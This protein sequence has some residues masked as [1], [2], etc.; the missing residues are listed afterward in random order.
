MWLPDQD[1]KKDIKQIKRLLQSVLVL[2]CCINW[3]TEEEARK[4]VETAMK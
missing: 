3:Y 2:L 1:L 4:I